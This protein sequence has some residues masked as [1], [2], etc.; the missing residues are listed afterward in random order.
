MMSAALSGP[1]KAHSKRFLN[2]WRLPLCR[3]EN[4]TVILITLDN[5]GGQDSQ[6]QVEISK[7]DREGNNNNV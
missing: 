1:A 5:Q 3:P 2:L 7:L 4:I 6:R